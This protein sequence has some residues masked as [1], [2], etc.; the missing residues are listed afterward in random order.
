MSE[1]TKPAS[2]GNE[3]ES[4]HEKKA[5]EYLTHRL[6]AVDQA[7]LL[8]AV[9]SSLMHHDAVGV[10]PIFDAFKDRDRVAEIV[11]QYD[12]ANS[13]LRELTGQIED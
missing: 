9:A 10:E 6:A 8:D 7:D 2:A 3:P 13:S 4:A 12:I 11:Y 5:R 1:L